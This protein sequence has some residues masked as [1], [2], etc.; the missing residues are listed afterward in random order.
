MT[1]RLAVQGMT[2]AHCEKAVAEAIRGAGA[3]VLQVSHRDGSALVDPAGI[4]EDVLR[5]A[6]ERAGYAVGPWSDAVDSP[7]VPAAVDGSGDDYDLII[8]GSGSAAFAAAITATD[9]GRRVALVEAHTVGGTCVN[10]GCLPSKA[11]LTAAEEHQRAGHLPFAGIAT[12]AGPADMA[13]VVGQKNELVDMLRKEKYLDL[14]ESYGFALVHG[15][16]RLESATAVAVGDRHLTAERVLIA[17]GV[18]AAIPPIDGL[19]DVAYLTSTTALDLTEVPEHLIVIGANA[20]GLE[21]GQALLHLGARVTFLEMAR[22]IAPTEEPEVIEAITGV[23][24]DEGA[25]VRTG[26]KVLRTSE[27]DRGIAVDIEADGKRETVRGSHLLV[28]TGRRPSFAGMGLTDAGI[29]LDD[30]GFIRVD[31]MLQ[32]SLPGVFAAGDA[33]GLPQ[34]VYVAAKSGSLAASNAFADRAEPLDLTALP[35]IVFTTPQIAVAGMTDAEANDRG[36]E[37]ECRVLP[38]SAVPRALVNH[39]TRGLVKIVADAT[40]RRV[41]GVSMVADGAADVILAAIYAIKFG[42]TVEQLGDTW[43]P[44]LTMG[45]ALKLAAQT[46]TR[47]VSKLSCCAA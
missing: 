36:Y 33:A 40:T 44:Y 6:V 34:F 32:T 47:D 23:L 4:S 19:R 37:C 26:V 42:V 45:E 41:L 8:I 5:S 3:V 10:V 43:G 38:L 14:A 46:F 39:D 21:L 31:D 30:H 11:L 13:A 17:S 20:I 24:D 29:E 18:E 7:G 35:R 15:H 28:A 22:T 1:K 9:V 25:T 16:A 12:S 2:C 27:D